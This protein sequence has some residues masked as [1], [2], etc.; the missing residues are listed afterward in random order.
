[1]QPVP[2]LFFNGNC[3]EAMR[4]YERILGGKLDVIPYGAAPEG[5]V[6]PNVDKQKI[7]HARLA[8]PDGG[9]LMAAD[10]CSGRPYEGTHGFGVSVEVRSADESKRICDAL[11]DGGNVVVPLGKT[12]WSEAFGMV[13]DRY[14]ILWLVSTAGEQHG[15]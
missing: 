3:A 11:A 14:G 1:M 6:P 10:D 12:F 8:L 4:T 13:T 2:Y 9:S 15:A 5:N 7:M